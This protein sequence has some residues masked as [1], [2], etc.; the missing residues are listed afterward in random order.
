LMSFIV[1]GVLQKWPNLRF[2]VVE[3]GWAW[4][5]GFAWRMDTEWKA[6]RREVPWVEEAPST[7]LRRHF[8]FTTQPSDLPDD[9]QQIRDALEQLGDDD[10][11]AHELLLHS[12]DFPH[13]YEAGDER[14][15]ECLTAEQAES[16]MGGNAWEWYR[17]DRRV[18]AAAARAELSTG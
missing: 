4:V 16:V 2:A 6:S 11:G 9:P 12:S 5:P 1:S 13:R 17:L 10:R 18:P 15:L 14:I 3:S 7:Y 8:R